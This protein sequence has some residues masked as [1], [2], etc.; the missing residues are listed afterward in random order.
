MNLL[1]SSFFYYM[2]CA[3]FVSKGKRLLKY[4]AARWRAMISIRAIERNTI[5]YTLEIYDEDS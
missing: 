4:R 3:I 1:R 5:D 2:N